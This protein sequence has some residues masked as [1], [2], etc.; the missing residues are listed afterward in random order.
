MACA[1]ALLFIGASFA[2]TTGNATSIIR[3][4]HLLPGGDFTGHLLITGS[5]SFALV[6]CLCTSCVCTRRRVFIAIGALI[7]FT[8]VDEC[9][10]LALPRRAFSLWDLGANVLGIGLGGLMAGCVSRAL[11]PSRDPHTCTSSAP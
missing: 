8:T 7:L 9:A 11:V 2:A 3:L 4:V 6:M 1:L 5:V 10:Q